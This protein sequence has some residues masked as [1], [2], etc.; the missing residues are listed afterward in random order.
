M[1]I[2]VIGCGSI[3]R[4]HLLNL[5]QLGY[6]DL[7]ACDI[8]S[9]RLEKVSKEIDIT[10]KYTEYKDAVAKE[11]IDAVVVCTPTSLHLPMAQFSAENHINIMVEKPISADLEGVDKLVSTLEKNNVIMMV[12]MCY[13]FHPGLRKLK[14]L[15]DSGTIGRVYTANIIGGQYLPSYHP[16]SDYRKEYSANKSLGGGII[17]DGIHSIDNMRWIFGEA[18]EVACYF[19]RV[20]ALEID[21]EDLA[22]FIFILKNKIV[23]NIHVDYLQRLYSNRI[24]VIG[25]KGNAYWDYTKNKILIYKDEWEEIPYSFETN[26]MYVEEMK[27]FI[28]C[29]KQNKRPLVDA[30]EGKKTLKLAVAGKE[31]AKLRKF[32]EL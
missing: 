29:L 22:T 30:I 9:E 1:R 16:K 28:G 5:K 31:S 26:D 11:K 25:E 23:V 20:S 3:G 4:R 10:K 14:E 19:D 18:S 21:T 24:E 7:I 2:M 6:E 32:V 17:L 15:L 13:R 8:N 12:A 27:H